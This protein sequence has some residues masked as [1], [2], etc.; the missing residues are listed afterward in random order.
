MGFENESND[1]TIKTTRKEGGVTGVINVDFPGARPDS[2]GDGCSNIIITS[3]DK[4]RESSE[5]MRLASEFE[6]V[7]KGGSV[8][9]IRGN[10]VWDDPEFVRSNS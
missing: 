6:F 7:C 2:C 8:G 1:P 10:T 3:N 4:V 5:K 9:L